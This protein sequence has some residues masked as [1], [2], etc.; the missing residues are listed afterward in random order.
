MPGVRGQ[1]PWSQYAGSRLRVLSCP[2][3]GI[4]GR[5]SAQNTR[6]LAAPMTKA[7]GATRPSIAPATIWP[8]WQQKIAPALPHPLVVNNHPAGTSIRRRMANS[9]IKDRRTTFRVSMS[10]HFARIV[11]AASLF[12]L[13][14]IL[15]SEH[16]ATRPLPLRSA[17]R[18]Q[19]FVPP[20]GMVRELPAWRSK[21]QIV[22]P[23]F[24]GKIMT[25]E[26][27]VAT[28]RL[29]AQK[30]TGPRTAEGK[31]T[32]AQNAV[33]HGLRAQAVVFPGEESDE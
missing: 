7:T 24:G 2:V 21:S 5:F 4:P 14:S 26:A 18:L 20:R 19:Y 3:G 29:N 25:T 10:R 11:Q 16:P 17:H 30:S 32:V 22:N 33:T 6:V 15:R 13:S 28:N 27:Q 12:F 8:L 31:A 9:P 23:E 1:S